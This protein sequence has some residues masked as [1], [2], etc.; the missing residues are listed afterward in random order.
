MD[1]LSAAKY[2]YYG[3]DDSQNILQKVNREIHKNMSACEHEAS[4]LMNEVISLEA[5]LLLE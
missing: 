5:M 4:L 3:K 1:F 2:R